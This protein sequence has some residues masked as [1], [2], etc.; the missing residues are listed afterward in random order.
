METS[1]GLQEAPGVSRQ[2][3]ARSVNE[4]RSVAKVAAVALAGT[5]I[6]WYDFFIY[7]I[8]AAL[9]FPTLFF[10]HDLPH[11]VSL[12]AAFST[13]AAGFVARPI[14][15]ILFGHFGDR[16]GR[17]AALVTALVIMGAATALIGCLPTYES[18]GAWA[19]L[20][21]VT[22][23]F[24]QGLAIGGQWGG[25]MLL[26]VEC[27]PAQRRG[28]FGGF[29]QA[30]VPVGLLLANLVFLLVSANLTQESFMSWGWRV[31]FLLS[32]GLVGLGLYIQIRLED[33][34]EFQAM[35]EAKRKGQPAAATS[36]R[37]SSPVLLALKTYPRQILLAAGAFMAVQVTI[38]ILI[39]FVVAYGTNPEGL[40]LPRDLML[41]ATLVG[42]LVM[43]P[44]V[45]VSAGVSDRLGRRGIYM[46]GA[47]LLAIWGFVLFPLIETGSFIWIAVAISV[48]QIFVAMM[49][50]PQAAFLA[51]LFSTKVRYSGA[52]LGYQLGAIIGGAPAPLIATLL[53]SEFQ[54]SLAVSL[55]IA[56]ACLITVVSVSLL[57]ETYRSDLRSPGSQKGQ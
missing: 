6:E 9:V 42:A 8:A 11:L 54:G 41:K 32:V 37:E 17:K 26:A 5:S 21:L 15:G 49:Y 36:A 29:A 35:K 28:L 10:S 24:M 14:G 46:A 45:F 51:E 12:I 18:A 44:A 22:L 39:A 16:H 31:P 34:P 27:A 20:M 40:N 7:G 25:A 52:S 3:M 48:G 1:A 38:Y 57:A 30:G 56:A 23:R 33:T 47:V 13:F 4:A 19:P 50:G 53:V 2:G 55:Y 43:V